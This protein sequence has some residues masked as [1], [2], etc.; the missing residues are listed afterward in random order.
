[1][2]CTVCVLQVVWLVTWLSVVVLNVDMGLAIGVVFSMMTVICRT[3]RYAM[4]SPLSTLTTQTTQTQCINVSVRATAVG[5]V[6]VTI[7]KCN[8]CLA[9]RN[10]LCTS[11]VYAYNLLLHLY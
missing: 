5:T 3:Q 1:M 8:Q 11:T 10:C 7:A 2:D 6:Q 4:P 9:K